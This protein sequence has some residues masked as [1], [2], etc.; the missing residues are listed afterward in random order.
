[1]QDQYITRIEL[2][3]THRSL[4]LIILLILTSTIKATTDG[5]QMAVI[6][7]Y[8]RYHTGWLSNDDKVPGAI[9]GLLADDAVLMPDDGGDIVTGKEAIAGWWFPNGKV[10]GSVELFR[11]YDTVVSIDE[12]LATVRGRFDLSF[13]V[14]GKVTTTEGNQLITAKKTDDGWRIS[15][16]TWNSKPVK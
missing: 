15:A 7:L 5:D 3:L 12:K 16:I 14:D 2:M 1:M 13:T 4:L 10:V 11:H 6:K 8:D 9:L